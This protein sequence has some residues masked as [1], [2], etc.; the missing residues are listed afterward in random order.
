LKGVILNGLKKYNGRTVVAD[1]SDLMASQDRVGWLTNACQYI[2]FAFDAVELGRYACPNTA[3]NN[4]DVGGFALSYGGDAVVGGLRHGSLAPLELD[5]ASGTWVP[6]QAPSDEYHLA[7]IL[8]FDGT[9]LVALS[10]PTKLRRLSWQALA[11]G[12][13]DGGR[14]PDK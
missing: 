10:E 5:R 13:V 11:P 4:S 7:S 6:T 9:T 12:A 14:S 8:G 1:G 2:E 3:K